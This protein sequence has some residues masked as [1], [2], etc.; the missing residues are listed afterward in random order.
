MENYIVTT[1]EGDI[2]CDNCTFI[3][4]AQCMKELIAMDKL[5]GTYE[6]KFYQIK[7]IK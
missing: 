3:E 4:A 7:R 5:D 2:V 6:K 1:M